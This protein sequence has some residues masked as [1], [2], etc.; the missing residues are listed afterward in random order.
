MNNVPMTFAWLSCAFHLSLGVYYLLV[1][2]GLLDHWAIGRLGPVPPVAYV[3]LAF[4]SLVL[5]IRAG[6]R[7]QDDP[8][9]R[10]TLLILIVLFAVSLVL[11]VLLQ[12]MPSSP[13]LTL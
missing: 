10:H 12:R 8:A 2:F 9:P 13:P 4:A 11:H 5:G 1:S 7:E 6:R 3:I